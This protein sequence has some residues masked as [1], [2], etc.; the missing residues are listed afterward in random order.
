MRYDINSV[1]PEHIR[2]NDP[3]LVAFAEAY[4]N[5]LDQDGAAGRILNTLPEYRDLDKVFRAHRNR[6]S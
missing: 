2:H 3:K 6:E 4:F 5:F 1:I